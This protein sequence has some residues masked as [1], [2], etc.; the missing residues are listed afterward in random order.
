MPSLVL[1]ARRRRT[2]RVGLRRSYIRRTSGYNTGRRASGTRTIRR[3]AMMRRG[4]FA[5]MVQ[6]IA[7]QPPESKWRDNFY[8][9][10]AWPVNWTDMVTIQQ[11][12]DQSADF[13]MAFGIAICNYVLL[14]DAHYNRDGSELVNKM[15]RLRFSVALGGSLEGTVT[16][17]SWGIY[18]I[19]LVWSV[20]VQGPL[21]LEEVLKGN[22]TAG[23]PSVFS[24]MKNRTEKSNY[25]ILYD[26]TYTLDGARGHIRYHDIQVDLK[27][28]R[29]TYRDNEITHGG[30]YLVMF[31]ETL[32][33]PDEFF[34]TFSEIA[35]RHFFTDP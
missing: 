20:R 35:S 19:M 8:R 15:I 29:S 32:S 7:G 13:N 5:K 30:L 34:P 28:R 14:G 24:T 12:V 25:F 27:N 23:V 3:D 2:R 1:S 21:I 9:P 4:R 26:K 16:V 18:R 22:S 10:S 11:A 31:R 6:A 17:A 33:S